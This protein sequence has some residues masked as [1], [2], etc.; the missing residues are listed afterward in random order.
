MASLSL[1]HELTEAESIRRSNSGN[2][3]AEQN[4]MAE[5]IFSVYSALTSMV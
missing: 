4:K 1:P 3:Y 5:L 2:N